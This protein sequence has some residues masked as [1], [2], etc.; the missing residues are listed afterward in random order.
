MELT[1]TLEL[2]SDS[3]SDVVESLRALRRSLPGTKF[4]IDQTGIGYSFSIYVMED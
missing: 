1:I 4:T 3:Y 2:G